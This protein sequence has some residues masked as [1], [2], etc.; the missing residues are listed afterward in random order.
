LPAPIDIQLVGPDM[1]TNYTIA[2]QI[3]NRLRRIPGTADVHVQQMLDLPTLHLNIDAT[4]SRRWAMNASRRGAER[5][6]LAEWQL[7]DAR[8][9]G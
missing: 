4:G 7:S 1:A 2:Q 8:I 3:S 6:G 5:A 9:S